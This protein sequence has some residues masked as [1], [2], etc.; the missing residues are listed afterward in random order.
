MKK[1]TFKASKKLPEVPV[2]GDDKRYN[3]VPN[4]NDYR[5]SLR[6][7]ERCVFY[8]RLIAPYRRGILNLRTSLDD[9]MYFAENEE[10]VTVR[11]PQK[12]K[13][14]RRYFEI[15]SRFHLEPSED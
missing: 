15:G 11:S 9:L 12:K 14:A 8:W 6:F 3:V 13:S 5:F 7:F 2:R 10:E 4:Y 1:S